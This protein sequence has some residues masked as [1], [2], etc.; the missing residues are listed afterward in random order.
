MADGK[1]SFSVIGSFTPETDGYDFTIANT[2]ISGNV[3]V[4]SES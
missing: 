3:A 2:R 1:P 4:G